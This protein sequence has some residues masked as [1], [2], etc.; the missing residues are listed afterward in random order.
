MYIITNTIYS[1]SIPNQ[2][3]LNN[4]AMNPYSID[5]ALSRIDEYGSIKKI[6]PERVNPIFNARRSESAEKYFGWASKTNRPVEYF[7]GRRFWLF[8][9]KDDQS[10]NFETLPNAV[11]PSNSLNQGIWRSGIVGRRRR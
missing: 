11:S 1:F 7:R 6:H 9:K 8:T 4:I 5:D 2:E 10:P 3:T